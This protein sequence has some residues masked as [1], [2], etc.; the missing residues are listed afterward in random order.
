LALHA[1]DLIKVTVSVSS[2]ASEAVVKDKTQ[3]VSRSL[4]GPGM[5][6][7]SVGLGVAPLIGTTP[8]FN[9]GQLTFFGDTVNGVPP[10]AA[11]ATAIDM[12]TTT[13]ILQVSTGA[14]NTAGNGWTEVWNHS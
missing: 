5:S 6:I 8:L 1:G 2:T 4:A 10:K 3:A 14:L 11:G 7:R 12:E 9:F 13:G